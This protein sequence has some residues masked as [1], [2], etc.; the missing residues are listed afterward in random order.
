M[1]GRLARAA[2]ALS[3]RGWQGAV[4]CGTYISASSMLE[5][6]LAP[7][8]GVGLDDGVVVLTSSKKA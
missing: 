1:V 6:T 4:R 2:A 3:A 7:E 5:L 8:H